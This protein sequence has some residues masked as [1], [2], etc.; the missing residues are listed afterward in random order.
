MRGFRRE[1]VQDRRDLQTNL[2][3]I[4]DHIN[5]NH[6]LWRLGPQ[7]FGYLDGASLTRI[8]TN[9]LHTALAFPDGATTQAFAEK[10]RPAY[11]IKGNIRVTVY[12]TGDTAST[13]NSRVS[14]R[15]SAVAAGGNLDTAGTVFTA[16]NTPGPSVVG[17]EH[18][19]QFADLIPVDASH[20]HIALKIT[21]VGGDAADTYAGDF[22]LT[23]VVVEFVPAGQQL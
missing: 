11:W 5:D 3:V 20:R 16:V 6:Y 18:S 10:H 21:R 4:E 12:Y 23:Q 1:Q 17:D 13:N 2:G 9:A 7:D 8:G 15:A 14:G 19:F 22:L